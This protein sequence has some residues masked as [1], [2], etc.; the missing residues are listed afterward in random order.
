MMNTIRRTATLSIA[1][2][3]LAVPS[4]AQSGRARRATPPPAPPPAAVPEQP[5]EP[6]RSQPVP[7]TAKFN[8]KYAGGTLAFEQDAKLTLIIKDGTIRFETKAAHH[9]VPAETV[10]EM[11][12]GQNVRTRTAEAVGV[13]VLVPGIGGII[14][15]SK[16]TAHYV[17]ILWEGSV[18]GGI[19][20]RVDKDDYRGLI[21]ALEGATGLKVKIEAA[22]LIKDIP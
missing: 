16:S 3:V 10:S 12:Y 2:A 4:L 8:V 1:I 9:E 20:V 5:S 11:S 15:N 14:G 6:P 13:G 21:A 7:V 18:L 22:P 17:E 19:A